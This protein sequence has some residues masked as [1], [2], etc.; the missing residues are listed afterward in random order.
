MSMNENGLVENLQVTACVIS[1]LILILGA[2][3]Q[4]ESGALGHAS[5]SLFF[6][7]VPL[8]GAGRELGFGRALGID[9]DYLIYTKSALL[10]VLIFLMISAIVQFF[11][12]CRQARSF[13]PSSLSGVQ[14][15]VLGCF[16]VIL[17]Q[18]FES[19]HLGFP[20]SQNA[21]E[22]FELA[23]YLTLV[24]LAFHRLRIPKKTWENA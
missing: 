22:I 7:V 11:R 15:M 9:R 17:G 10:I 24:W 2:R 5:V 12:A 1:F 18:I 6:S 23:G 3:I 8:L 14:F 4:S 19:G 20:K 16:L 13:S 21:E